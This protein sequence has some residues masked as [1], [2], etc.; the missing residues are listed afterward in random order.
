[1]DLDSYSYFHTLILQQP[2]IVV[3]GSECLYCGGTEKAHNESL[4]EENV[5]MVR[6]GMARGKAVVIGRASV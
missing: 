3:L 2:L 6:E 5:H 4:G 1:M